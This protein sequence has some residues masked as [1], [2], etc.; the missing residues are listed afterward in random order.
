MEI[1]KYPAFN[2]KTYHVQH[3]VKNYQAYKEAGTYHPKQRGKTDNLKL[4]QNS[5]TC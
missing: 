4:L 2:E 5:H 1:Q 3:P